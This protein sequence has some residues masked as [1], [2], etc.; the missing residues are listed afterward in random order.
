MWLVILLLALAGLCIVAYLIW[1]IVMIKHFVENTDL[2]KKDENEE[3][4]Q[5]NKL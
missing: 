4:F 5:I 3:P 1:A 2:F